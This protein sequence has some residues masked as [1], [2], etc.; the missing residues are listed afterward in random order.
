MVPFI[1]KNRDKLSK[2]I[3]LDLISKYT[4]IKG[5]IQNIKFYG[6]SKKITEH[7]YN[8]R[9]SFLNVKKMR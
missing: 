8:Y 1:K 2:T 4:T 5:F 7:Q 9:L 3:N 6:R